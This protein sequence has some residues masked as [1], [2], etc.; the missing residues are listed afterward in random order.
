M[1]K[2]LLKGLSVLE[3]L[4]LPGKNRAAPTIQHLA[5]RLGMTKSNMH[6]TLQTLAH[7][8]Y[9]QRDDSSGSYSV[10][11]KLVELAARQLDNIDLRRI[12]AD[13]LKKLAAE[14]TETVHL[15]ILEGSEVV[16]I[17][18]IDSAHPVRAYSTIGGRAPAQCVAT[19]KALLAF[20]TVDP[21]AR[22][23]GKLE[24]F[25]SKSII[26]A[27]ALATELARIR[28]NGYAINRGEWR[29]TVGGLAAPLFDGF[30]RVVGAIGISGPIERLSVGRMKELAPVVLKAASRVSRVMGYVPGRVSAC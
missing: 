8:G 6:R 26:D 9:A 24:A 25:T 7:A 15:S 19:G 12:A 23:S 22:L 17:D 14:T 20:Q 21:V 30:S 13:T 2:T 3:A 5:E 16:Y 27:G 29:E 18:K 1:D 28:K 10:T 11:T 4:I